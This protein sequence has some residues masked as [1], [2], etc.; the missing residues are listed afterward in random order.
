MWDVI[1]NI[2]VG[3][4][5]PGGV[6][7]GWM[8][9]QRDK[10]SS[11]RRETQTLLRDKAE[12]IFREIEAARRE[13]ARLSQRALEYAYKPDVE[14]EDLQ[15]SLDRLTALVTLYF[16]AG[17]TCFL[18]YRTAVAERISVFSTLQ[19]NLQ[20]DQEKALAER[21]KEL[22]LARAACAQE[23]TLLLIEFLGEVSIFMTSEVQ[24]LIPARL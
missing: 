5:A 3:L 2:I 23:I 1:Q 15:V 9:R 6:W 12:E 10:A 19:Q 18:P 13:G 24:K 4:L 14:L 16:P 20:S 21:L 17:S 7:L 8:L 22:K 11:E